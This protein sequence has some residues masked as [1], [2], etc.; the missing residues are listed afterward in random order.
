MKRKLLVTIL[1]L[2]CSYTGVAQLQ[3]P[4]ILLEVRLISSRTEDNP[5]DY[6]FVRVL[7]G[8]D[9]EYEDNVVEDGAQKLVSRKSKLSPARLK[10]LTDVLN[11]PE[12]Q[13]APQEYEPDSPT[14]NQVVTFD[15]TISRTPTK[16]QLIKLTN[17]NPSTRDKYPA[18]LIELLCRISALRS[19]TNFRSIEECLSE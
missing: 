8:G 5:E 2:L 11:D 17:Y 18:K 16:S 12:L 9:I 3:T 7:E 4:R 15:I 6:L 13:K 19:N 14:E 1:T 10:E